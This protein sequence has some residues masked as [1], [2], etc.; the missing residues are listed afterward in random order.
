M[1]NWSSL[2]YQ[3]MNLAL[4]QAKRCLNTQDVPVGAVVVQ[5]DTLVAA[6]SNQKEAKQDPT[7]H[8]EIV[9]IRDAC[10]RLQCWNLSG[11]TLYVTLE[12][13]LMCLGS[14]LQSRLSR[15]VF[16]ALEPKT[17]AVCSHACSALNFST[18]PPLFEQGLLAEESSSLLK[19]FFKM[20]RKENRTIGGRGHRRSQLQRN[21][22]MH[23]H[24][25]QRIPSC[26][27]PTVSTPING[28]QSEA[29]PS[30]ATSQEDDS[31][32]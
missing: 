15:V 8:A 23:L 2:D 27:Y 19:E 5:N 22:E 17:G 21:M 3:W 26:D 14:I 25:F 1:S 16:G 10:N 18:L 24:G 20:R 29:T 9:A 6:A 30:E 32:R 7:A 13:C 4:D 12:P 31:C 28:G 11:F